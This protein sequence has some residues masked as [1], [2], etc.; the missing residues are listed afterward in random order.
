MKK[1]LLIISVFFLFISCDCNQVV[2]GFVYDKESNIP[3]EGALVYKEGRCEMTEV[4]DSIGHFTISNIAGG[5][6]S[7]PPMTIIIKHDDY[8]I[9]KLTIPSGEERSVYLE[10]R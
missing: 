2:K 10:K 7:C 8:K 9:L 6:Q 3:I 4:T 5:F 1:L